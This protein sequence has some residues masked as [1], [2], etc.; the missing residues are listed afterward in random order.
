[1]VQRCAVSD[2]LA[3]C[4]VLGNF[5]SVTLLSINNSIQ[6]DWSQNKVAYTS[7]DARC[8]L[9]LGDYFLCEA[10]TAATRA[11]PRP[12]PSVLSIRSNL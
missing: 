4:L 7:K 12:D 3:V 2:T 10:N 1:M 8:N 9:G 11:A 6:H 5:F